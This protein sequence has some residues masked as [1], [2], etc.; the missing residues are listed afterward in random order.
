M[1]TIAEKILADKSG[2][3][4]VTPGEIVEAKVDYIMVNDVTGL[5]AFEVFD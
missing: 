5:P 4:E 2:R 3:K 1:P